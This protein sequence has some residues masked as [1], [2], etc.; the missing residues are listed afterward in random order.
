M[1]WL[2]SQE[3]NVVIVENFPDG[4]NNTIK[5]NLDK[6][7]KENPDDPIIQLG[8]N[9]LTSNVKLS[10]NVKKIVKQV[11][12]EAQLTNLEFSSIIMRKD[13]LKIR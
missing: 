1:Y 10:K 12:R 3:C 5:K 4:R 2:L 7:L 11:S 13:L 8:T 9:D 6:L